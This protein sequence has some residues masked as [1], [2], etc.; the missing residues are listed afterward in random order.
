MCTPIENIRLVAD[1]CRAGEPLPGDIAGWLARSL[2]A[3]LDR[4]VTTLNDAFGVRNA[5]GGVDWRQAACIARRDAALRALAEEQMADMGVS[6]KAQAINKL[7]K[8]YAATAWLH[9]RRSEAMP[10]HYK[11]RKMQWLWVAFKSE[12]PMPLCTRRL[13]SILSN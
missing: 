10:P 7:S 1:L 8:H 3:Y 5:R 11:G 12:A 4:Q 9:D 6:A 2:E 13:R